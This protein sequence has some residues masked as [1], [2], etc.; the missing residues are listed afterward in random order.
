MQVNSFNRKT[1]LRTNVAERF[2]KIDLQFLRMSIIY[3][4]VL[5]LINKQLKLFSY[6][7]IQ[8]ISSTFLRAV[9]L[10]DPTSALRLT[11]LF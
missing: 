3:V 7:K 5:D 4:M 1:M 8:I 6:H 11:I 2:F 10:S 9:Y